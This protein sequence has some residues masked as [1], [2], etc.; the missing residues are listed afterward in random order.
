MK[1]CDL[2]TAKGMYFK[3]LCTIVYVLGNVVESLWSSE[4]YG[5]VQGKTINP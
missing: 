4:M 2:Y 5:D 3:Q 1:S